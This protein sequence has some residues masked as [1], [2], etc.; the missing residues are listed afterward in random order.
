MQLNLGKFAVNI[1]TSRIDVLGFGT[2]MARRPGKRNFWVDLQIRRRSG[3][4]L[5]YGLYLYVGLTNSR[6][7][8]RVV[9]GPELLT[10]TVW[11]G[12][13]IHTYKVNRGWKSEVLS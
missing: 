9:P 6:R 5:P 11:D 8:F 2:R 10:A 7:F 13:I 1:P 12:N 4:R 3:C